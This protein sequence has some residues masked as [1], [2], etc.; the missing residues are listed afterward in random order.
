MKLTTLLLSAL[1]LISSSA[2][3]AQTMGTSGPLG[4]DSSMFDGWTAGDHMGAAKRYEE[5]ARLLQAEARGMEAAEGKILPYLEVEA[6]QA[7]GLNR[8][9]DRR[10]KE[11]EEMNKLA[12]WHRKEAMR[13]IGEK[14]AAQGTDISAT[15][16]N[17]YIKFEWLDEEHLHGW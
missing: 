9:I 1:F 3:F 16:K 7:A 13:L 6:I 12:M 5:D 4:A 8:L 17:P 14:E 11:S 15:P 10:V 2:V